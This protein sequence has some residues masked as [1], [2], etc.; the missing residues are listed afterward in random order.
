MK[1]FGKKGMLD[2]DFEMPDIKNNQI[3]KLNDSNINEKMLSHL[4]SNT[5]GKNLPGLPGLPGSQN[6]LN[7]LLNLTG[8]KK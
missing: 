5:T 2:A 1:K 4:G 6:K 7:N 3:N 8:R